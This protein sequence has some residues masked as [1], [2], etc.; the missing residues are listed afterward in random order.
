[1]G[2]DPKMTDTE[3]QD[4]G[5]FPR[6]TWALNDW[7]EYMESLPVPTWL[8][9]DFIMYQGLTIVSGA[10]TVSY[11]SWTLFSMAF[12][13]AHGSSEFGFKPTQTEG[14][15]V[16]VIELESPGKATANRM[17]M[18]ET[19][20]GVPIE[21]VSR[22]FYFSH[23][24]GHRLDVPR[25]VAEIC[26]FVQ[27]KNIQCVMIDTLSKSHTGNE[28]S[29]QDINK[30]LLSVDAIRANGCAVVLVHHS[31]KISLDDQGEYD[32]DQALRGSTATSG[33]YDV[34]L[35]V[36]PN[37]TNKKSIEW[38]VRSNEAGDLFY[39]ASWWF[40]KDEEKPQ[41]KL[42]LQ[43]VDA[44]D[45]VDEA[46]IDS[47][48]AK[49]LPDKRYSKK[50]LSTAWAIPE[51]HIVEDILKRLMDDGAMVVRGRGFG[52]KP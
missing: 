26:K 12:A 8:L 40:I 45:V 36:K 31:R 43:L 5:L 16:W 35:H 18:I 38:I 1:M 51:Q 23:M 13:L 21:E 48:L 27:E 47:C 44:L 6:N 9:E 19:G 46:L 41:V 25:D 20:L 28:N 52:V 17:R 15:P 22:N 7:V 49:L 2:V 4:T 29:S 33:G 34:H 24:S 3:G 42:D 11:K 10:P 32:P 37:P 14:V 30:V 50:S 39:K